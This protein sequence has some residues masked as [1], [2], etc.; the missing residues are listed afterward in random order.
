VSELAAAAIWPPPAHGSVTGHPPKAIA[1][2]PLIGIHGEDW[3]QKGIAE[4]CSLAQ[5]P[6]GA[7]CV[8]V[9]HDRRRPFSSPSTPCS[10]VV[11]GLPAP[12]R[13][14][15]ARSAGPAALA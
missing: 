14:C 5:A 15:L 2:N 3:V 6:L 1:A 8:S 12:A 7:A 10:H 4:T 11:N 13:A 9:V